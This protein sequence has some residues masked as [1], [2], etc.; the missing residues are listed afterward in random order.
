MAEDKGDQGAKDKIKKGMD[1]SGKG[2]VKSGGKG[3]GHGADPGKLAEGMAEA[4]SGTPPAARAQAVSRAAPRGSGQHGR[5]D[6]AGRPVSEHPAEV[7]PGQL[8]RSLAPVIP[9][10]RSG[11]GRGQPRKVGERA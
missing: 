6:R 11:D 3:G 9:A 10:L 7:K 1:E 5:D 4:G 8:S 2:Q